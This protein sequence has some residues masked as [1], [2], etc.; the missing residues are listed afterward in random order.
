MTG[1]GAGNGTAR[2]GPHARVWRIDVRPSR[3]PEGHLDGALLVFEDV[4]ACTTC[5][6]RSSAR[7]N[8]SRRSLT[9]I[10]VWQFDPCSRTLP[11]DDSSNLLGI[12]QTAGLPLPALATLI[13]PSDRD[14]LIEDLAACAEGKSFSRIVSLS[15]DALSSV[16]LEA[17]G[18]HSGGNRPDAR[19]LGVLLDVT[20]AIGRQAARS[21]RF[22]R[23]ITGSRTSSRRSRR[24]CGWRQAKR[25]MR[26]RWSR[27]WAAGSTPWPVQTA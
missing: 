2:R 27:K 4:T 13:A 3:G 12:G 21:A 11:L 5:R 9:Q 22:P 25:M 8:G 10:A 7:T 23:W 15:A 16:G 17:A 19:V 24:C 6:S 18:Q 1:R 14:N 26:S 20:S